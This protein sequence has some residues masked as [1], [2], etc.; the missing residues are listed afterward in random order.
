M[1]FRV[2]L[3]GP[4]KSDSGGPYG[5]IKVSLILLQLRYIV[6]DMLFRAQNVSPAPVNSQPAKTY[7][8]P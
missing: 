4:R 8:L 2:E 3:M 6:T 7:F 5:Q 1:L